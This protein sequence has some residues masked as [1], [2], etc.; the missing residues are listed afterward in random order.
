LLVWEDNEMLKELATGLFVSAWLSVLGPPAIAQPTEQQ[1][2]EILQIPMSVDGAE[3]KVETHVYIPHSTSEKRFPVVVFSHGN[4]VPP[5]SQINPMPVEA[6]NW[7]VQHGFAVVAPVRPGYGRNGGAFRE[8]QNVTWQGN[9]CVT[10]PTYELAVVRAREVVLAT[11]AWT[12]S[13]SWADDDRILLV[14]HSTGGFTTIATA[15]TNPPGVKAAINFAGGMGGN[16]GGSPGQSCKPERIAA[17]YRRFGEE[18]HV[19][20]VWIYTANDLFWGTTEPRDWFD[21]FKAGGSD[22]SMIETPPA[23]DR[24]NGHSMIFTNPDMWHASVE[25]FLQKMRP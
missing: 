16:A 15:A 14:G 10:D 8:A 18:I 5:S 12:R 24:P 7:W 2:P 22:V 17:L 19:P 25:A 4:G 21:A 20:T 11:L 3:T 6:A 1:Q 9:T 23:P 13:Q